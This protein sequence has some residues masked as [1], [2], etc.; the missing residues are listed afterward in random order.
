MTDLDDKETAS[1]R[2]DGHFLL[3][4]SDTTEQLQ[5]Y[6]S[7]LRTPKNQ[8]IECLRVALREHWPTC[9]IVYITTL[10]LPRSQCSELREG[11]LANLRFHHLKTCPPRMPWTLGPYLV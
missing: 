1:H 5:T 10:S 6:A 9:A 2:F 3:P 7:T 8:E 4:D 11:T